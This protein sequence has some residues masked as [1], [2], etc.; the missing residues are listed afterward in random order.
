MYSYDARNRIMK[1]IPLGIDSYEAVCQNCY[2]V[3]KTAVISS[4]MR[5]PE[6]TSV[7]LT[8]PRRFGKSLMLSMLQSFFEASEKDKTSLFEDKKIFQNKAL[9]KAHFQ[10]Y[11]VLHLNL[12]NAIASNYEGMIVKI[13]EAISSEYER[14][15][16]LLES[17]KL[18]AK[19]KVY[20]RSIMNEEANDLD[21]TSSLLKL[22]SYMEKTSL[23]K[24]VVLIDEYDAPAHYA[25]QNGFYEPAIL[26][27]KQ[28]FSSVLKS[29]D[30]LHLALLTGV[31]QIAKESLFSGLNN[32]IT[33]SV[34]SVNMD[35]GFGFTEEETK[36][37]LSYYGC[38]EELDK[39]REWYGNY[40]FGNAVVYNPL[41]VLSFLQNGKSYATYWNNTADNSVLGGII[42][43]MSESD[44]LLPLIS[45]QAITSPVDI[46]LS[47][48]D[49]SSTSE[50]ILSFLLASGYLTVREK[51]SD[52]FCSLAFPNKEI[53][54]VF[55]R[56]IALRYIPKNDFP[57]LLSMKAA[58]EKGDVETLKRDL[59]KYLLSSFSCFEIGQEKNYQVMLSTALSLIFE[60][61]IVKNE[62]NAG[63]GRADILVYSLKEGKPAFI[64][65]TKAL[66]SNASQSRIKNNA[67]KAIE[68]IKEKDYLD[69]IKPHS[70]SFVMLY[71]VAFY[72]KRVHIEQE[73]I[74][75]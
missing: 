75:F 68:Q 72:K 60:T 11:P 15:S 67:I 23:K 69:E 40:H 62:A 34:L 3:D 18:S 29:N 43:G 33:N 63:T 57:A 50:N 1:R 73:Q 51:L 27:L 66:R 35:E 19:D 14:H 21:Y 7:L 49:L 56:E 20:F 74:A 53:E 37:L 24:A 30:S 47:Y 59:E 61:C 41:S 64:I 25:Y 9:M 17:R 48:K 58:F 6:G 46:A 32:L 44:S 26:F 10:R 55:Q 31:L 2:Y 38:S 8:R 28:L 70:P 4:L 12:K 5:L 52:F 65:E 22:T 16:S 71:G 45:K 36:E 13:K 42:E 54:S 39:V